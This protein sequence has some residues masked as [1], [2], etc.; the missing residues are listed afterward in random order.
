MNDDAFPVN[1]TDLIVGT[2]VDRKSIVMIAIEKKKP[3]V[4]KSTIAQRTQTF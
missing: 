2:R 3:T 1:G 4:I